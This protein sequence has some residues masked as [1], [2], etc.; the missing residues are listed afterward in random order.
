M[1]TKPKY[2]DRQVKTCI[3]NMRRMKQAEQN[4]GVE[5]FTDNLL[6]VCCVVRHGA[7]WWLVPKSADGWQHRQRL[8]LTP[9]VRLD[10]LKPAKGIT[11]AWLG[12]PLGGTG[13]KV[14]SERGRAPLSTIAE[15]ERHILHPGE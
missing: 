4:N 12:V 2:S 11:A 14:L 8:R 13:P 10:R 7:E 3:A 9:E 15:H 1:K 6:R 5:I